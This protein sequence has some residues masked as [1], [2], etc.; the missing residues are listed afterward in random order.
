M[1]D[2]LGTGKAEESGSVETV[3]HGNDLLLLITLPGERLLSQGLDGYVGDVHGHQTE[4]ELLEMVMRWG[5]L[6]HQQGLC[7]HYQL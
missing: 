5:N 3:H 2:P 7:A 4:R 6:G 1:L